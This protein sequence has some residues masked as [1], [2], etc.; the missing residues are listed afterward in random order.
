[1][2]RKD[3][4]KP[5]VAAVVIWCVPVVA[6]IV[7]VAALFLISFQGLPANKSHVKF[8]IGASSRFTRSQLDDVATQVKDGFGTTGCTVSTIHYDE[9]ASDDEVE[10]EY[11]IP[12]GE[13]S[14]GDAAKK[15]GR[16]NVVMI[17]LDF[18][19]G[20]FVPVYM[21]S[22]ERGTFHYCYAWHHCQWRY[23]DTDDS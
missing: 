10:S 16:E 23:I 18:T 4:G 22:Y 17:G 5:G 20:K 3:G 1:M 19:C 12:F 11:S 15:Y 2:K 8:E 21:N 13:S 7:I 14:I 6:V 9:R